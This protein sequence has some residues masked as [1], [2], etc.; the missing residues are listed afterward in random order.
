MTNSIVFST[1]AIIVFSGCA[2]YQSREFPK[3]V[4]KNFSP[5]RSG[6]VE[7]QKPRDGY[8]QKQYQL[9]AMEIMKKFCKGQFKVLSEKEVSEVIGTTTNTT[10]VGSAWSSSTE[11]EKGFRT[12]IS[13]ECVERKT[14]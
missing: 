11:N 10:N 2:G 9:A 3:L 6:I 4:E 13:F 12:R 8:E 14:E 7:H 5:V 1:L